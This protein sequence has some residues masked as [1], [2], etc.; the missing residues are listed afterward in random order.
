MRMGTHPFVHKFFSYTQRLAHMCPSIGHRLYPNRKIYC[1]PFSAL[2]KTFALL[3][4]EW[5]VSQD[6][7]RHQILPSQCPTKK[8]PHWIAIANYC[9]IEIITYAFRLRTSQY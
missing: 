1:R 5:I 6:T 4:T 2:K 9:Y 7:D 8:G 3:N